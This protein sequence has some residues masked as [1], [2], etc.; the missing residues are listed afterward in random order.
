MSSQSPAGNSLSANTADPTTFSFTPTLTT[1]YTNLV[2]ASSPA[3]NAPPSPSA[4]LFNDS[5]TGEPSEPIDPVTLLMICFAEPR[6]CVYTIPGTLFLL[7]AGLPAYR[8]DIRE[9]R[10]Q[11]PSGIQ[12]FKLDCANRVQTYARLY[13]QWL[14]T[15]GAPSSLAKLHRNSD[16]STG[17]SFSPQVRAAI[18]QIRLRQVRGGNLKKT[19]EDIASIFRYTGPINLPEEAFA[20]VVL[21]SEPVEI[22]SRLWYLAFPVPV[23]SGQFVPP[24]PKAFSTPG[25]PSTVVQNQPFRGVASLLPAPPSDMPPGWYLWTPIT[26]PAIQHMGRQRAR[27]INGFRNQQSVSSFAAAPQFEWPLFFS[28]QHKPPAQNHHRANSPDAVAGAEEEP[29]LTKKARGN[30]T[31][32]QAPR[33]RLIAPS[34]PR[35]TTPAP[36][37][38]TAAGIAKRPRGR[39]RNPAPIPSTPRRPARR[40]PPLEPSTPEQAFA[41]EEFMDVSPPDTFVD[42]FIEADG[43]H[44]N[45][46]RYASKVLGS[47][48][49]YQLIT[50]I[51]ENIKKK[52][53]MM[54]ESEKAIGAVELAWETTLYN[55][56][57]WE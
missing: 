43:T 57:D 23:G 8:N 52:Q 13:M 24:A 22:P 40:V 6:L 26:D 39:P 41:F 49:R 53:A 14:L 32:S 1:S 51:T 27:A 16:G 7:Y 2:T 47:D 44:I 55:P 36:T 17:V 4:L 25:T 35:Q 21:R 50:S 31:T 30:T 5:F 46:T 29:T 56:L 38:I 10:K 19:W 15:G 3:S 34:Q 54:G 42:A 48:V 12:P 18:Y 33:I 11:I 28:L 9:L 37:G 45:M 20:N